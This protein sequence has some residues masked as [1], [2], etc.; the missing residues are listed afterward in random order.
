MCLDNPKSLAY[1][2]ALGLLLG[3]R[4]RNLE[5]LSPDITLIAMKDG[6]GLARDGWVQT[7]V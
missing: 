6:G 2:T 7:E 4:S 5:D 3:L 1:L